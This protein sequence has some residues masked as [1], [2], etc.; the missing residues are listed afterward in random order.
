MPWP[1]PVH[2]NVMLS[3]SSAPVL[4]GA[5]NC[6]SP[7]MQELL[8]DGRRRVNL[9]PPDPWLITCRLRVQVRH[10]YRYG[11]AQKYPWVTHADPYIGICNFSSKQNNFIPPFPQVVI[12]PETCHLLTRYWDFVRKSSG[13]GAW[14]HRIAIYNWKDAWFGNLLDLRWTGKTGSSYLR[15]TEVGT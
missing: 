13:T 9:Y 14:T 11:Y 5:C 7:E 8:H 10:G 3:L 12:V 2:D 1:S 15:C 4:K 6:G